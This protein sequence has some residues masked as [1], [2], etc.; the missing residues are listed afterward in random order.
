MN[1]REPPHTKVRT[2]MTRLIQLNMCL[3]YF[4]PDRPGQLVTS[5]PKDDIKEIL[6]H[7]MPNTWRKKMVEQRYNFLDS[8]IN[9][10]SDFFEARIENLKNPIPQVFPQETGRK[11]RKVTREGKQQPLTILRTK[12]LMKDIKEKFTRYMTRA[13]IL[14]MVARP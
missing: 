9:S 2:F 13:N 12:I 6:Y 3:P 11:T 4:P 7:N 1:L 8:P 10:V 14:Q 5:L